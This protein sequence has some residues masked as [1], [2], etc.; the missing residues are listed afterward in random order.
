MFCLGETGE[1]GESTG[2]TSSSG[3]TA[4][5]SSDST[6]SS[7]C[8]CTCTPAPVTEPNTPETSTK[9]H[10]SGSGSDS[11]SSESNES[12]RIFGHSKHQKF[13][14]FQGFFML[15]V[16]VKF[17][18]REKDIHI[19]NIISMKRQKRM[20]LSRFMTMLSIIQKLES[21]IL[22]MRN[23]TL[24]IRVRN[25]MRMRC[26]MLIQVRSIMRM[27]VRNIMRIMKVRNI[28]RMRMRNTTQC[29]SNI[30]QGSTTNM[31]NM[32]EK[33]IKTSDVSCKI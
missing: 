19:L 33:N 28:M 31:K 24:N 5:S 26:I 21:I 16:S 25:K 15:E 4:S 30:M 7:G 9:K 17:Q 6:A 14:N 3:V 11:K 29:M 8:P 2:T 20:S 13:G 22:L 10:G 18:E 23:I 27:R 12:D 32:K 1:S